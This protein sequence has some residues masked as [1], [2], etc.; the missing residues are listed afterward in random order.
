MTETTRPIRCRHF[1]CTPEPCMEPAT[2]EVLGPHPALYCAEHARFR[3]EEDIGERW[4]HVGVEEYARDCE[5]AVSKLHRWALE[6]DTGE[7]VYE[8]LEEAR[9]YL[10]EYELRRARR[11]LIESGGTPRP[12]AWE[13]ERL[14]HFRESAERFGWTDKPGWVIDLETWMAKLEA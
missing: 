14:E 1:R 2:V 11:K 5:A 3:L 8:V 13:L 12:T 9:T 6:A 4:E 10:E 7:T